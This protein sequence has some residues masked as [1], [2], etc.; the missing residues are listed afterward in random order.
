MIDLGFRCDQPDDALEPRG[1]G[2]YCHLCQ[3]VVV[4]LSRLTKKRALAIVAEGKRCVQ[5]EVDRVTGELVFRASPPRLA[6]LRAAAV[7]GVLAACGDPTPIATVTPDPSA[8]L[9]S[10]SEQPQPPMPT[11]PV[12]A[13]AAPKAT[14]GEVAGS[15]A[16]CKPSTELTADEP[17]ERVRTRRFRGRPARSPNPF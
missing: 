17:A 1:E 2:A 7:L 6:S 8:Q 5:F 3:E 4:D 14:E 16:D 10:A 15:E 11:P 9:G 13:A 12:Q